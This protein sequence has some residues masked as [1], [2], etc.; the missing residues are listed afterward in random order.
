MIETG[1]RNAGKQ[2]IEKIKAQLG[3]VNYGFGY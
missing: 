2:D 1:I 3:V